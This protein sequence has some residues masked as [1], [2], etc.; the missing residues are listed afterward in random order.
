M[1]KESIGLVDADPE[2]LQYIKEA[3]REVKGAQS[4]FKNCRDNVSPCR[5]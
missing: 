2:D 4:L 3:G 5:V 1:Y